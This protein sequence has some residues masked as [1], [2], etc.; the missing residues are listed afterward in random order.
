ML[1]S[2]PLRG[3][4]QTFTVVALFVQAGLGFAALLVQPGRGSAALLVQPGLGFAALH[5]SIP[6]PP[7]SVYTA[8][9]VAQA[10]EDRATTRWLIDGFN[11]LHVALLRGRERGAW[12]GR[13]GRERLLAEV[14]HFEDPAAEVCVVFDGSRPGEEATAT[15]G[16]SVVFA[17][18]ADAWLLA[19][20]RDAADPAAIALVTAD[21]P[22]ADRARHRGARIVSPREFLQ[23]C[24]GNDHVV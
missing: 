5:G 13:E 12:W 2:G 11:V 15:G 24:Q 20:V 22:L 21:K 8:L 1:A 18:S 7:A 19:Q 3:I 23:R 6:A 16:P 4:L 17:A 10:S 9:E 14:R